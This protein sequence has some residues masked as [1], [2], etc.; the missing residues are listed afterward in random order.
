MNPFGSYG[1]SFYGM[2]GM[3]GLGGFNSFGG[4]GGYRGGFGAN[5]LDPETR[6]IQLAEE[7]SRGKAQKR[8]CRVPIDHT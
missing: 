1:S 4:F 6:F 8:H 2:G 3:G 7:S 5:P